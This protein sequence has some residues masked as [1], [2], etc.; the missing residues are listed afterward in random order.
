M[1]SEVESQASLSDVSDDSL[2][3]VPYAYKEKAISLWRKESKIFEGRILPGNQKKRRNR[4][5]SP[6]QALYKKVKNVREL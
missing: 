2:D 3:E 4:S 1:E 5:F 6:V